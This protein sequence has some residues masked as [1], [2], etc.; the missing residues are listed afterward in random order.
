MARN[1]NG[2]LKLLILVFGISMVS[3]L[4]WT[5]EAYSKT[6]KTGHFH[7][8][9]SGQVSGSKSNAQ[10]AALSSWASFTQW[11]YGKAWASW[12]GADKRNVSCDRL[13]AK[14][15]HCFATAIPCKN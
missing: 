1:A 15:W 10:K 6:C 5:G 4:G 12:N 8:G 3:V 9:Y 14:T 13:G 11:E 7:N 2:R